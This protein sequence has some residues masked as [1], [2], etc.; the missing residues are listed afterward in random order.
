M[1]QDEYLP[2][3]NTAGFKVIVHDPSEPPF[4]E[5]GGILVGPGVE[6][7]IGLGLVREIH[8][9]LKLIVLFLFFLKHLNS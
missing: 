6:T 3:T 9:T 8:G 4:P 2:L 7:S 5:D 1:E